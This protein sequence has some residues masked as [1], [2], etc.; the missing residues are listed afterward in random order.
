LPDSVPWNRRDA[1]FFRDLV[2]DFTRPIERDDRIHIEYVP[3]Q[4]FTEYCRLAWHGEFESSSPLEGIIYPSA[5]RPG[6]LAIVLF[7][8]RSSIKGAEEDSVIKSDPKAAWIELVDVGYRDVS[9]AT[10]A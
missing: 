9:S 10:S 6:Q 5:R 4:V 3:T 1:Q 8:D 2:E 7:D